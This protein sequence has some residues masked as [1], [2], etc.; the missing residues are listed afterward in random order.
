MHKFCRKAQF[1]QNFGRL[2]LST[3]L[4]HKEIRWNYGILRSV[5]FVHCM[6]NEYWSVFSLKFNRQELETSW[7]VLSPNIL[8]KGLGSKYWNFCNLIETTFFSSEPMLLEMLRQIRYLLKQ[9]TNFKPILKEVGEPPE[10]RFQYYCITTKS[11]PSFD[12]SVITFVFPLL[13]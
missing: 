5:L 7:S 1:Q 11:F 10:L 13:S 8:T 4:L 12:Q 6:L 3:K 2:C 9:N